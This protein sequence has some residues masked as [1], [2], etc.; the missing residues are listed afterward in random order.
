MEKPTRFGVGVFVFIF[1]KDFS[2]V[3]LI[4]RNEEKRN[5][6]GFTWGTTGGKLEFGEYSIDG[7]IREVKEEI[8]F[9]LKKSA[10]KRLGIRELPNFT[11]VVHGFAFDYGAIL[12]EKAKIT[13]NEESDDYQ[14]FNLDNLPEDRIKHDNIVSM[15]KIAKEKF[16][17]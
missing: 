16:G 14:W 13:L 10:I 2:K 3:L 5:K 4:K 6:Y 7:A 8:G 12:D 9:E 17:K 11:N 15:A 1:N